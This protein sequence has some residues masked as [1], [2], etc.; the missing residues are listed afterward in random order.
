MA[1]AKSN[2]AIFLMLEAQANGLTS[3]VSTNMQVKCILRLDLESTTMKR[4][5]LIK[6]KEK[7]PQKMKVHHLLQV[8]AK[9][10][11]KLQKK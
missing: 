1:N 10:N 8:K 4:L 3:P 7:N 2:L 11:S 5:R 6:E 9:V